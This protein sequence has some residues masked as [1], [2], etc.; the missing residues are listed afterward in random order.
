[1]KYHIATGEGAAATA[2][3]ACNGLE[4]S[5]VNIIINNN[6]IIGVKSMVSKGYQTEE[7][8]TVLVGFLREFGF[9]QS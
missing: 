7:V 9:G 3:P 5:I 8:Q 6:S 4:E 2:L 1:M